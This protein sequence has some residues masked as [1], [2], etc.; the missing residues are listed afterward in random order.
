[1]P[2]ARSPGC[3]CCGGTTAPCECC[4]GH[5]GDKK[6]LKPATVRTGSYGP[7][8]TTDWDSGWVG[9]IDKTTNTL[10]ANTH[11]YYDI[12][13]SCDSRYWIEVEIIDFGSSDGAKVWVDGKV[14]ENICTDGS[15]QS[16]T[17]VAYAYT[18]LSYGSAERY[19]GIGLGPSTSIVAR[20]SSSPEEGGVQ[21]EEVSLSDT[22]D[23]RGDFFLTDY[24]HARYRKEL[25]PLGP[26]TI[27]L[28]IESSSSALKIGGIRI[29]YGWSHCNVPTAHDLG[30]TFEGSHASEGATIVNSGAQSVTTTETSN[31][32]TYGGAGLTCPADNTPCGQWVNTV[33]TDYTPMN[34]TFY[35]QLERATNWCEVTHGSPTV[36]TWTS[37]D[38]ADVTDWLD[39]LKDWDWSV[40]D[41][42]RFWE[43]RQ[44]QPRIETTSGNEYWDDD[45]TVWNLDSDICGTLPIELRT[46]ATPSDLEPDHCPAAPG[47]D[48]PET[49]TSFRQTS[50]ASCASVN[51]CRS[52]AWPAMDFGSLP[53]GVQCLTGVPHDKIP[54]VWES[55]PT[56][57]LADWTHSAINA[58]FTNLTHGV[59]CDNPLTSWNYNV[60]RPSFTMTRDLDLKL[61]DLEPEIGPVD[62]GNW[63]LKAGAITGFSVKDLGTLSVTAQVGTSFIPQLI[64]FNTG[65]DPCNACTPNIVYKTS[66]CD[67]V[68]GSTTMLSVPLGKVFGTPW[69]RVDIGGG[70]YWDIS[71]G[72]D[73][74]NAEA[75]FIAR[76]YSDCHKV[77]GD[78]GSLPTDKCEVFPVTISDA[79]YEI[80]FDWKIV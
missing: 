56:L 27:R 31:E 12:E 30:N 57:T 36:L 34:G 68:Y 46:G 18:G 49:D 22:T 8:T 74:I 71:I 4:Y 41:P 48:P 62:N 72:W 58:T 60:S 52:Q 54:I 33:S 42:L 73:F 16:Q 39:A 10:P 9:V 67:P 44:V 38:W 1:M 35:Y 20:F 40:V 13:M 53:G 19:S 66:S 17:L 76:R 78:L 70:D 24:C 26:S 55:E 43:Y 2:I 64:T 77:T 28:N 25:R 21:S 65:T 15:N 61:A 75:T 47:G 14:V 50:V 63:I 79:S 69:L 23:D 80:T 32:A 51:L 6:F 29:A 5:S 3:N 59:T 11:A 7:Y 45:W 37:A